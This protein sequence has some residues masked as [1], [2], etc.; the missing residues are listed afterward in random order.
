LAHYYVT[1][2]PIRQE[3]LQTALDWISG[4]KIEKY[5][6]EHQH[7]KNTDELWYYFKSGISL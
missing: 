4:E 2:T 5:M 1:G 3:Y 6:A 7:D